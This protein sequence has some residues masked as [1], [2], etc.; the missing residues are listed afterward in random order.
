MDQR[1][2]RIYSVL[3]N[4]K[5]C[6]ML[7]NCIGTIQVLF[8]GFETFSNKIAALKARKFLYNLWQIVSRF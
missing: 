2:S 6:A 4:P 5:K 7:G 1:H 8:K 3:K